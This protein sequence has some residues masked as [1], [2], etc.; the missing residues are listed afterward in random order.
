MIPD[1]KKI[2]FLV[3]AV[4]VLF[5]AACTKEKEEKAVKEVIRPIKIMTVTSSRDALQRR[6]P[7]RVRA[8]MR[9]DLAFQ[10]S[11]PLIELPIDEG[12]QMKKGE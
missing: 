10:V 8:A 3:I 9:V 12:Q 2:V 6:F 4:F 7:G 11:G 5:L 1:K